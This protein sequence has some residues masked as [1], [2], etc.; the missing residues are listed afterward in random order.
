MCADNY[1]SLS[2]IPDLTR[3]V[4]ELSSVKDNQSRADVLQLWQEGGG[5][6][7]MGYDMYRNLSRG[8]HIR[9][10]KLKEIMAK[11]LVDPG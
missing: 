7:I 3:Q 8:G 4:Y 6:L 11:T 1:G 5:I 2:F 10:K 9:K